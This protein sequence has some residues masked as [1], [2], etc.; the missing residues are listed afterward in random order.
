MRGRHK[1]RVVTKRIN[2]SIVV[3]RK[4][5]II[6]GD[7]ATGKSTLANMV[8]LNN[9]QGRNSGVFVECDVEVKRYTDINDL[10]SNCIIVIDEG[11]LIFS[12]DGKEKLFKGSNC[13]F[14]IIT[15]E[16][17]GYL[18]YSFTS[19]YEFNGEFANNTYNVDM[20]PCFDNRYKSG[21]DNAMKPDLIITEDSLKYKKV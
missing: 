17:L 3:E 5:T 9:I 14:I 18:P 12:L 6:R 4:Y 19:V 13:Y 20:I 15:R 10:K 21:V 1:L 2:F 7:S 16:K 8:L 11:D